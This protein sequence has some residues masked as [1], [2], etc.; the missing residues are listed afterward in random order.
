M[1][2][3]QNS[4]TEGGVDD[5]RARQYSSGMVNADARMPHRLTDKADI[6]KRLNADREWSLYALADLDEE[7]FAH[8]DWWGVADGLALVFRG[9]AIR[10]IFVLGDS[11]SSRRLLAALPVTTGYLNLKA[12]QLSAADGIYCYRERHEMHRMFLDAFEPRPGEVEVLAPSACGEVEQLYATGA[13]G[14]IAF[15]PFQ[16]ESGFFRGIRRNGELVAVAG[17]HAWSQNEGVAAIGNIFSR[18]DH[19]GR[20]LAQIVT[21]AVA[22]ALKEAGIQTIGLNV[23]RTNT[24]AIRAYERIGFRTHFGYSEGIA[25]KVSCSD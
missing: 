4:G 24:V 25:D 7:M 12:E 5:C 2:I 15:A 21:S 22:A 19:R 3:Q 11:S 16:L 20:G 14:G 23:D 1:K 10:P 17:V 18:P 9:I 6:R 13:G 8:C